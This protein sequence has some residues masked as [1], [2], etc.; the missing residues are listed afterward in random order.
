MAVS[1]TRVEDL[2]NS[3]VGCSF[4]VK[5]DETGLSPEDLRDPMVCLRLAASAADSVFRFRSD[6]DLLAAELPAQA[7][8]KEALARE[9][10][11]HP[12]TA[13]WFDDVDLHAQSWLS[14]HGTLNKFSYGAPPNTEA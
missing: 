11:E 12:G 13:W 1:D 6:Y 14:V 8:K 5:I 7:K 10:L 2:L 3:L 4:L 9:V